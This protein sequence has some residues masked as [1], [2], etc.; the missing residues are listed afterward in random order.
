MADRR[1][2]GRLRLLYRRRLH[3]LQ[4]RGTEGETLHGQRSGGARAAL[5]ARACGHDTGRARTPMM[6]GPCAA[7]GR[8]PWGARLP[9]EEARGS[10]GRW[11]GVYGAARARLRGRRRDAAGSCATVLF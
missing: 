4:A 6:L 5:G 1:R 10:V 7:S 11:Y 2:A 8:R 3:R 9:R